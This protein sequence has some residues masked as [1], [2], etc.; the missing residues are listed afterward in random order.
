MLQIC[1]EWHHGGSCSP[2]EVLKVI[3]ILLHIC[4]TGHYSVPAR[5]F[6]QYTRIAAG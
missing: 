1:K 5:I 3:V 2:G 4:G 6:L